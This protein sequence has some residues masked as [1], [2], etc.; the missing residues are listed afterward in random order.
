MDSIHVGLGYNESVSSKKDVLVSEMSLLKI[1]KH[2]KAYKALKQ[3]EFTIK[4]KIKKDLA[5]LRIALSNIENEF[6]KDTEVKTEEKKYTK[7][8]TIPLPKKTKEIKGKI[9][10]KSKEKDNIDKELQEIREKLARLE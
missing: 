9:I 2:I 10:K 4:N 5:S 6:P 8:T 1:T 7:E 3:R